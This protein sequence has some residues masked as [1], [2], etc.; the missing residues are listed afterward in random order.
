MIG[1]QQLFGA[2]GHIVWWQECCRAVVIFFF[3]LLMVRCA[4]RRT[5]SKWSALDIII[6]IL[7]GS[8]LSRALTGQAPFAGTLLATF[9]IMALHLLLAHG[10]A[11]FSWLSKML[12]GRSIELAS[13]G[14]LSAETMKRSAISK[15]DLEEALRKSGVADVGETR[16]VT[17]EPSGNITV[18]KTH[19]S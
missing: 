9:V 10:A 1:L 2:Q 16:V 5:F 6:S 4:G 13:S 19:S 18:L 17:L 15:T 8:N 12:E 14:Q 3:G 7:V 11:R